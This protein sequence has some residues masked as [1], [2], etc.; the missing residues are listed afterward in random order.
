VGHGAAHADQ[1]AKF[2]SD[3]PTLF[4]HA[5]VAWRDAA[6]RPTVK[7]DSVYEET[8]GKAMRLVVVNRI[9]YGAMRLTGS[10]FTTW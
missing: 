10:P 7:L 2:M 8:L 4:V 5:A 1:Q 3:D 9:G 6:G